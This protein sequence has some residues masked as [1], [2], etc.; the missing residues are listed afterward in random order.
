MLKSRKKPNSI[1]ARAI[2]HSGAGHK[3]W[4]KFAPE[5]QTQIEQLAIDINDLLFTPEYD[6]PAMTTELPIG[7]K[8]HSNQT[9]ELILNLI[10]LANNV[11]VEDKKGKI[12]ADDIPDD[13][14][15]VSTIE[16]L[17]RTKQALSRITT[18]ESHSLG[19]HPAVY[20]YSN[21]GRHQ[22]TSLMAWMEMI[23][24]MDL[25]KSFRKF[26]D[27]RRTFEDFFLKY[28]IFVNQTITKQGSGAKGYK[29][30]F[31]MFKLIVEGFEAGKTEEG[32]LRLLKEDKEFFFLNP[33]DKETAPLSKKDFS[34]ENKSVVYFKQAFPN[35]LVCALCNGYVHPKS[36]QVDHIIKKE[37]GGIGHPDN[38]QITHPYCNSIK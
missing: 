8:G 14:E 4:S 20:F 26:K 36:M 23:K 38:G 13:V 37:H 17:K 18:K 7:G 12:E 15:G 22:F 24:D 5:I 9:L 3:Y 34:P 32:I 6:T 25:H 21:T 11:I 29:K 10:N 31:R 16:Y 30:L 1:A 33:D 28:K 35:P 2:I 19:L 27:I